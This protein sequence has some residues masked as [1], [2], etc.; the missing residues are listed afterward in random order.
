MERVL[1]F[2]LSIFLSAGLSAQLPVREADSLVKVHTALL[3]STLDN[4]GALKNNYS[5]D[6]FG[7]SMYAGAAQKQKNE[8]EYRVNWSEL[9]LYRRVMHFASREEAQ[10]I[11][12]AK[13]GGSFS[14]DIVRTYG[15]MLYAMPLA[16]TTEKPLNGIRIALDPGHMADDLEMGKIEQKFLDFTIRTG[17]DSTLFIQK[18]QLVEGRLTWQ[19]AELLK[20]KLEKAGA[21]VMITRPGPGLCAFGTSFQ[22]WRKQYYQQTL[23]SLVKLRGKNDPSIS[24]VLSGKTDDRS[25]FRYVFRDVELR[26]RVELINAFKPDFTLMIHYNVDEKN[27]D[28]Q[29]PTAKNFNMC[30]V[31]GSYQAGE[32]SDPERRFDFLRQLLSGD[33]ESSISFS[34]AC[35]RQF[36]DELKVPLAKPADALYLSSSCVKTAEEGVYARNLGLTRLTHGTLVYGETLYQDNKKECLRL[37]ETKPHPEFPQLSVSPRV[38]QVA[39]AYYKALLETVGRK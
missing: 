19:T 23:D 14:P 37:M 12:L 29:K 1:V 16:P 8:P 25:V 38:A 4:K 9:D 17:S 31:G 21:I 7:V 36:R 33:M 28:W 27:T 11:M 26:K 13:K 18:V 6:L 35:A 2:L 15:N 32:L 10:A 20:L 3:K 24:P 34:G 22:D 30:F 39:D 5:I